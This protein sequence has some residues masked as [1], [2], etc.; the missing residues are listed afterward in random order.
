MLSSCRRPLRRGKR[1]SPPLPLIWTRCLGF[2]WRILGRRSS[3]D[4]G[5]HECRVFLCYKGPEEWPSHVEVDHLRHLMA[6]SIKARQP[7][8]KKRLIIYSPSSP[9][10]CFMIVLFDGVMC[11]YP[12]FSSRQERPGSTASCCSRSIEQYFGQPQFS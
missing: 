3:L 11:S 12:L 7:K 1:P 4:N 10:M 9:L 6:I 8:P 5:L 2:S